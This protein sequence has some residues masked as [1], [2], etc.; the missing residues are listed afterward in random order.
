MNF[1][2][3]KEI[4][5]L[6]FTFMGLFHEK[7]TYR[8]RQETQSDP[9]LKKNHKKILHI[10]YQNDK[11]TLTEIGRLLDI[12]KGSL[13]TLIDTLEEQNLVIRQIA[14][15]DRRKTY[16]SL[17]PKGKDEMDQVMILYAQSMEETLSKVN[18]EEIEDFLKNLQQVVAFLKKV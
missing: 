11:I 13:T 15:S 17:S 9:C 3:V 6:L 7:F 12:E 1:D 18:P 16:I 2:K 14:S 8:H 5:D 10:L 4:H